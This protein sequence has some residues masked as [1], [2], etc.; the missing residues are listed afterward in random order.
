MKSHLVIGLGNRLMGD[1]GV[2]WHIIDR[3]AGDPRLPEDAELLWGGTDLLACAD[4]IE[5][6]SRIT[7]VDALLDPSQVGGVA[8][9]RD[10]N[11][12]RGLED[13]QGHVHHLSLTQAIQL[14]RI[15]SPSFE[16]ARLSLIAVCIDSARMQPELSPTLAARMPHILEC[17]LQELA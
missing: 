10:G 11:G 12:L 9:F 14:L 6:R 5:G 8:V 7:L 3:L 2:G 1:E 16:T 13:R 4:Q 15:N 17:V